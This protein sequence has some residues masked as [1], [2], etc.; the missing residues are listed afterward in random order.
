M[1]ARLTL[2]ALS[3]AIAVEAAL[4]GAASAHGLVQKSD[5][6]IPQWLLA[7]GAVRVLSPRAEAA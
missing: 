4:P 2:A 5:L 6:P 3:G 7:W 1:R